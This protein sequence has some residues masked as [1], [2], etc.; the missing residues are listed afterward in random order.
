MDVKARAI[1]IEA[2]ENVLR[3]DYQYNVEHKI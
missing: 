3:E 2:C 1:A